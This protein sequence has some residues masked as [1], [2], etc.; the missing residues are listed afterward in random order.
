MNK[1][2]VVILIGTKRA[3]KTTT[4]VKLNKEYGW[5]YLEFDHLLD[6]LDL[7]I[8]NTNKKENEFKFFES[9]V[10]FQLEDAKNYGINTIIVVYDFKP[11]QLS[12]LKRFNEV[13]IYC[14]MPVS[15]T[16][17]ILDNTLIKYSN[18]YD[19][20]KTATEDDLIRNKKNILEERDMYLKECPKYNIEIIDT[21]FDENRD[22][23]INDLVVSLNKVGV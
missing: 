5:N 4:A 8:D 11:E 9:T 22:V 10:N 2:K 3:G 18:S 6:S 15:I 12:K 23:I 16:E 1:G 20:P 14:L 19:W 17:E 21:S 13:K 7:V